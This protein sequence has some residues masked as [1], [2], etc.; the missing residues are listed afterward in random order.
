MP[1]MVLLSYRPAGF[2][3]VRC[4]NNDHCDVAWPRPVE[5]ARPLTGRHLRPRSQAARRMNVALLSVPDHFPP[6]RTPAQRPAETFAAASMTLM[7]Q[8]LVFHR[9]ELADRL[10]RFPVRENT[11]R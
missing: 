4:P 5:P 2:Q 1:G 11:A 10:S 3:Q 8:V 9:N 7:S 6:A